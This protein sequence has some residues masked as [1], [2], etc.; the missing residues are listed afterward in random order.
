MIYIIAGVSSFVLAV[1]FCFLTGR[2]ATNKGRS[3]V[4]YLLG[5]LLGIIAFII[6]LFLSDESKVQRT[7]VVKMWK[8]PKCGTMNN[9]EN[10]CCTSCGC[11]ITLEAGNGWHCKS[12]GTFN[13][14][15]ARFCKKC[16]E[17]KI[18]PSNKKSNKNDIKNKPLTKVEID[19]SKA[20]IDN[21]ILSYE[22]IDYDLKKVDGV[23]YIDC[24]VICSLD[25]VEL[26]I[27]FSD[28][29]QAYS[30]YN[31]IDNNRSY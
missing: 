24:K 29:K 2:I 22:G 9:L 8:C 4:W 25:D 17:K 30:F 18:L 5:F 26:I 7:D 16:G 6:A 23:S 1:V 21:T 27:H 11:K 12:C 15:Q 14:P 31:F 20:I 3:S 19:Y 13:E 28:N 10:N